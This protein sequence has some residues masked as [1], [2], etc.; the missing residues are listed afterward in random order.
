MKKL[1]IRRACGWR[2][3]T[4]NQTATVNQE[5]LN[6]TTRDKSL[7]T[8]S[9]RIC[10]LDLTDTLIKLLTEICTFGVFAH[11][12]DANTTSP[13]EPR[14]PPPPIQCRKLP[15]ISSDFHHCN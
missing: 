3:G 13:A 11:T 9:L 7:G 2:L 8:P 5:D 10:K 4:I 15:A 14:T 12:S 6:S 1:L